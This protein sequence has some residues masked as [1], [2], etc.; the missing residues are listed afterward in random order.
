M[1]LI[2]SFNPEP[3]PTTLKV[4]TE[5]S[6]TYPVPP[7]VA[8]KDVTEL[9]LPTMVADP[10][11]LFAP[12]SFLPVVRMPSV[13]ESAPEMVV[14]PSVALFGKVLIGSEPKLLT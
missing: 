8:L 6:T 11:L 10:P 2:F 7:S 5:V 12:E 3:A 13:A 4:S 9:P 1:L 14:I